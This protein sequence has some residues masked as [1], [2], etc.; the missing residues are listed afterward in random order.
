VDIFIG[1][2]ILFGIYGTKVPKDKEKVLGWRYFSKIYI[3]WF[4]KHLIVI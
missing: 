2:H 4:E 1:H 3:S